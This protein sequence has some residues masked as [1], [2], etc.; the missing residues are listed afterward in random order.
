MVGMIIGAA[1]VESNMEVPQK[2]K[3]NSH[4]IQQV[5]FWIFTWLRICGRDTMPRRSMYTGEESPLFSMKFP[6]LKACTSYRPVTNDPKGVSAAA[7]VR[8][9]QFIPNSKP[10]LAAAPDVL[11]S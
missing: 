6:N 7:I 10:Q 11:Y 8:V 4:V 3:N 1:T 9:S 5:H 2:V